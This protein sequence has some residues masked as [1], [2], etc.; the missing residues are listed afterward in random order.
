MAQI[1]RATHVIDAAGKAPGRIA[2]QVAHLLIGKHKTSFFPNVDAGDFVEVINASKIAPT[3]T[4]GETKVYSHH[5]G[6]PGGLRQKK[7]QVVMDANPGEV[8]ERAVSR[9]LPKNT[10]REQRMLRLTIKP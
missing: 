8:I 3:G 6:W 1:V 5:T 4:K 10:T 7:M 2:T 9:M